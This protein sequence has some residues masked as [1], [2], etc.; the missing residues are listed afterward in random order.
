[1]SVLFYLSGQGGPSFF[2][3]LP[4]IHRKKRD[5]QKRVSFIQFMVTVLLLG[6]MMQT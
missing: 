6:L 2:H 4:G 5:A 3:H 1:M